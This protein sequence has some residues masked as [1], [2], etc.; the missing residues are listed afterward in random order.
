MAKIKVLSDSGDDLATIDYITLIDAGG[1]EIIVIDEDGVAILKQ[2]LPGPRG[3]DGLPGPDGN[4]GPDG[5]PGEDYLGQLGMPGGIAQLGP[6]GL[7]LDSQLP[8]APAGGSGQSGQ[9]YK[10]AKVTMT[11]GTATAING[12]VPFDNVRY[13]DTGFTFSAGVFTAPAVIPAT[14]MCRLSYSY[15]FSSASSG[16]NATILRN[17]SFAWAGNATRSTLASIE[18]EMVGISSAWFKPVANETFSFS[19]NSSGITVTKGDAT[20]C[21]LEVRF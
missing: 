2:G 8:E 19:L 20:W 16:K 18:R 12:V 10:A 5:Q 21:Q 11:A 1:D 9:Q 13:N 14:M 15:D 7:V 4:T 3:D 6:D 17:G